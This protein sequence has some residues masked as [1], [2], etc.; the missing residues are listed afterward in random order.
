MNTWPNKQQSNQRWFWVSHQS[1]SAD[2]GLKGEADS[3]PSSWEGYSL[4]P[5]HLI[6]STARNAG[7]DSAFGKWTQQLWQTDEFLKFPQQKNRNQ[8]HLQISLHNNG[9]FLV[10][11]C[12]FYPYLTGKTITKLL[13][14][15][16]GG[17][18]KDTRA[19]YL[20]LAH[21][22]CMD[23]SF[24][25]SLSFRSAGKN[26]SWTALWKWPV[27]SEEHFDSCPH[28]QSFLCLL[29]PT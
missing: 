18:G 29:T 17:G 10:I 27:H 20:V 11:T 14:W 25:I 23:I 5:E 21:V 3:L 9:A 12:I 16:G 7:A 26:F 24:P 28:L 4:E 22:K 15:L 6:A 13:L 19:F 8:Q 1:L 2:R